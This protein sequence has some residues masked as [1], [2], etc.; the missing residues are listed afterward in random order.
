M[1][2]MSLNFIFPEVCLINVSIEPFFMVIENGR[3]TATELRSSEKPGEA[4]RN[5]EK[6][7]VDNG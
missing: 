5:S 2:N 6:D 3:S 1:L 7:F 4:E